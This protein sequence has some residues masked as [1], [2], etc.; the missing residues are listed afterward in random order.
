MRK[1]SL[2][3]VSFVINIF[4]F[5]NQTCL[6]ILQWF[7]KARNHLD[8]IFV[9]QTASRGGINGHIRSIHEGQN[10][11]KCN[12]CDV[13]QSA[14]PF[15]CDICNKSFGTKTNLSRHVEKFHEGKRDFKCNL[16]DARFADNSRL[17]RHV[18]AVHESAKQF[19]FDTKMDL[20]SRHVKIYNYPRTIKI[21]LKF[22]QSLNYYNNSLKN[23]LK[24]H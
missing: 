23:K 11:F 14:K 21:T 22:Q 7:M 24:T 4:F 19:I 17:N 8:V 13:H 3:N 1:R 16:C 20:R 15:M 12:L 10:D 2:T 9:T 6:F 5:S 18:T